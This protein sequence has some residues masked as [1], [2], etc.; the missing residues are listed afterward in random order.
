MCV[1]A[2]PRLCS[3]FTVITWSGATPDQVALLR[4]PPSDSDYV[5]HRC[6]CRGRRTF[7]HGGRSGFDFLGFVLVRVLAQRV[8]HFLFGAVLL[9]VEV[10]LR[11]FQHGQQGSVLDRQAFLDGAVRRFD[12]AGQRIGNVV[13]RLRRR[14]FDRFAPV[15]LACEL[16]VFRRPRKRLT[17]DG[18]FEE[19]E[20]LR[21]VVKR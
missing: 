21:I 10:G 17:L 18:D 19:L 13:H 11:L 3:V 20:A 12:Q 9:A 14:R 5:L 15:E 7:R 2:V 16:G 4:R 8:T 6:Q 1:V